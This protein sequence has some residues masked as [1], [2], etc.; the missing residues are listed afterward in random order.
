M[1]LGPNVKRWIIRKMS[2]D[3]VPDGGGIAAALEFLK[4][5]DRTTSGFRAATS[6]VENRIKAVRD[7]AEPN[8]WKHA[9]DEEIAAEVIRLVEAKENA[10]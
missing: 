9:T 5:K 8:K 7:A 6:W 1:I 2:M 4:D 10:K 3:A